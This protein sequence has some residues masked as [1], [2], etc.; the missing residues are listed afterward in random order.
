MSSGCCTVGMGRCS[1]AT[2]KGSLNTTACMVP[3]E[4]V[5]AMS[6]CIPFNRWIAGSV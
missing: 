1:T 2:L 3:G 4:D 6:L 5:V